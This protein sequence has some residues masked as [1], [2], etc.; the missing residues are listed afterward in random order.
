MLLHVGYR[1]GAGVCLFPLEAHIWFRKLGKALTWEPLN[2]LGS[3][4][5]LL[6][7]G[8]QQAL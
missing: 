8:Q 4:K 1:R 7:R 5:E 2:I 6:R 3:L